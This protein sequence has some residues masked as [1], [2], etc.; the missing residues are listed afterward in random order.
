MNVPR[1]LKHM[2]DEAR[3]QL[4]IDIAEYG[5]AIVGPKL[6]SRGWTVEEIDQ[7]HQAARVSL[8]R[9]FT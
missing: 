1:R 6:I 7:L 5:F 2:T 8:S 3:V 9:R 4:A